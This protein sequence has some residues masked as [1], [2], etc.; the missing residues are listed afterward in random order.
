MGVGGAVRTTTSSI[1][2]FAIGGLH[3][4]PALPIRKNSSVRGS[5]AIGTSGA[6]TFAGC[7]L[8][9]AC[10]AKLS[11]F[12]VRVYRLPRPRFASSQPLRGCA[13]TRRKSTYLQGLPPP[14]RACFAQ[15]LVSLSERRNH[16]AFWSIYRVSDVPPSALVFLLS[17]SHYEVIMRNHA[18]DD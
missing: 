17:S 1:M 4:Y 15:L 13:T 5:V 2:R 7:W 12:W 18:S 14:S 10:F 6:A 11:S 9:E 3:S 8:L 16:S